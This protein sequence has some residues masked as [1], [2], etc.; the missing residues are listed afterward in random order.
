MTRT[1]AELGPS[2]RRQARDRWSHVKTAERNEPGHHVWR[3]RTGSGGEEFFLHIEHGA[4]V[5]GRNPAGALLERLTQGSWLDRLQE[6]A[7]AALLL[8]R[9]GQL[10]P[11]A[12]R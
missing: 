2:L 6:Q 8:S 12:G 10:V 5:Q 1:A 7:G 4:M 3:F 11:L 9:D